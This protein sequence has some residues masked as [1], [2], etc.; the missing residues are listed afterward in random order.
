MNSSKQHRAPLLSLA[1]IAGLSAAVAGCTVSVEAEIPEVEITQS[2]LAFPGVP[3]LGLGEVAVEKSFS[4]DHGKLDMP[5]GLDPE[6]KTLGVTVRVTSGAPDISFIHLLR[7]TMSDGK[8]APVELGSYER[9][10][11]DPLT[12]ELELAALNPLD[13]FEAWNT[14][15][16]TFTLQVAGTLP[17][18]DWTA[19]VSVRFSARAKYKYR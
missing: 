4:Q 15:S 11:G 5:K 7:L 10:P 8:N 12:K 3:D 19:E 13:V 9:M 1:F 14:D 16:A 6:V 2:G 18:A 17:T